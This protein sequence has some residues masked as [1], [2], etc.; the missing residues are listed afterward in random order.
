MYRS[1]NVEAI[2]KLSDDELRTKFNDKTN[3]T[4]DYVLKLSKRKLKKVKTEK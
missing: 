3:P 1:V 4:L 2:K